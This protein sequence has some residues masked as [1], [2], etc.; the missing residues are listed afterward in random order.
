[1]APKDLPTGAR[2][3]CYKYALFV[4]S[5]LCRG[6]E[7]WAVGGAGWGPVWSQGRGHSLHRKNRH[8]CP[9]ASAQLVMLI[10]VQTKRGGCTSIGNWAPSPGVGADIGMQ[11]VDTARPLGGM[12]SK[13][14]KK[15]LLLLITES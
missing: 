8:Q 13:R 5:F 11:A 4:L 7:R 12:M 15:I 14:R 3:F 9:A 10:L 1:M 2:P 6:G